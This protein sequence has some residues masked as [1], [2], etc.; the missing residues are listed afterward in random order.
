[1][2]GSVPEHL[3]T[4]CSVWALQAAIIVNSTEYSVLISL[5]QATIISG[6]EKT[7]GLG[8]SERVKCEWLETRGSGEVSDTVAGMS[9]NHTRVGGGGVAACEGVHGV[10]STR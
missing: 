1:M 9:A 4:A 10:R 8:S 6:G 3:H 5:L 2:Y 7:N